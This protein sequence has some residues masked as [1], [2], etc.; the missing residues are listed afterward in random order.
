M[1]RIRIGRRRVQSERPWLEALSPDLR[2]PGHRPGQGVRA[3]RTLQK[4]AAATGTRPVVVDNGAP[5]LNAPG[6][7]DA[8]TRRN[9]RRLAW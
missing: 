1:K 6:G 8:R 9:N 4:G 7:E 2:D 3:D 5:P